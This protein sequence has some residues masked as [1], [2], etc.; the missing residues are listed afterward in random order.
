MTQELGTY[1]NP[2]PLETWST[3]AGIDKEGGLNVVLDLTFM[4]RVLH[5]S[6]DAEDGK[7]LAAAILDSIEKGRVV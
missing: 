2:F 4:G 7:A 6:T 3:S 5:L 1:Y